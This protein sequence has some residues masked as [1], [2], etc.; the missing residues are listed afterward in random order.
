MMAPT[1]SLSLIAGVIAS[2]L[3][4]SALANEFEPVT[5]STSQT[6]LVAWD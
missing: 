1:F 4:Y 6:D 2:S 3:P 5:L